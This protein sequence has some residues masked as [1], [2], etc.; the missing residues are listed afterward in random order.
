M[1]KKDTNIDYEALI[2]KVNKKYKGD[3][4]VPYMGNNSLPDPKSQYEYDVDRVNVIKKCHEDIKF[5]AE[6]FFYIISAGKKQKIKLRDYQLRGLECFQKYNKTIFNTSR[7]VGKTTL[8]GIYVVWLTTFFEYR[9]VLVVANKADTAKEI[10]TRI[11]LAY[12][13]LP[14]WIKPGTI[15]WNKLSVD[16]K[17]GSTVK[18]SATSADAARGQSLNCLSGESIIEILGQD[19]LIYEINMEDITNLKI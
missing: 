5:F 1:P 11:K 8:M 19:G 2:E 18:I 6:H 17:N 14:N 4:T 10:L 16:F 3:K 13:E 9:Q 12:E 15:G 7:Q